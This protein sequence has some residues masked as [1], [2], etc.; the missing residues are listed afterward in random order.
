M[1]IERRGEGPSLTDR[2]KCHEPAF[3]NVSREV[4]DQR[5]TWFHIYQH[6]SDTGGTLDNEFY[7]TSDLAVVA[8]LSNVADG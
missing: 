4:N 7:M 6:R 3:G 1:G 8:S 5:S 2:L